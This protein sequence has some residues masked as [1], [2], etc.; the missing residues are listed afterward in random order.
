MDHS[1]AGPKFSHYLALMTACKSFV[2]PNSSFAWWA[3]WLADAKGKIVV[4]PKAWFLEPTR[5]TR[6]LIPRTWI[7]I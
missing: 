7:R 5:D 2:I 1:F 6:D 4:A 3:A